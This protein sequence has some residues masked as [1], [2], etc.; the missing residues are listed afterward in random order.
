MSGDILTVIVLVGGLAL[1]VIAVLG[2]TISLW[3]SSRRERQRR[4]NQLFSV[5]NSRE[6]R[7]RKDR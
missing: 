6:R 1:I 7:E 4:Q 2:V 3:R 5:Y